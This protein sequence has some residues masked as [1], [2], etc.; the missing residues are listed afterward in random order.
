MRPGR[1]PEF[2]IAYPSGPVLPLP[3]TCRCL[4][5]SHRRRQYLETKGYF[6][7][8]GRLFSW[9]Q[10]SKETLGLASFMK[11]SELSIRYKVHPFD[12]FFFKTNPLVDLH[13]GLFPQTEIAEFF[14]GNYTLIM[15]PH[16]FSFNVERS[17]WKRNVWFTKRGCHQETCVNPSLR[18]PRSKARSAHT[19]LSCGRKCVYKQPVGRKDYS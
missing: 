2:Q 10:L 13:T 19:S 11:V 7:V 14:V 4:P 12:P 6:D 8:W 3:H 5:P 9:L 16:G 18:V 1:S 15:G 17:M